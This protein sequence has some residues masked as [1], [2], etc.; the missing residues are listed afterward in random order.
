MVSSINIFKMLFCIGDN[1]IY[2]AAVRL[3]YTVVRAGRIYTIYINIVK[4]VRNL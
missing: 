2:I 4:T 3:R 1:L